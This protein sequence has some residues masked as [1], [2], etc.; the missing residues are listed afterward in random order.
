MDVNTGEKG[1]SHARNR[2]LIRWEDHLCMMSMRLMLVKVMRRV[3]R[4][5]FADG[6]CFLER[7]LR[8]LGLK[9]C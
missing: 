6:E 5:F 4:L 2:R 7:W 3:V 8:R 9:D 1:V